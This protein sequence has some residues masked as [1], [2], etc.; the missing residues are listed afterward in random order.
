MPGIGFLESLQGHDGQKISSRARANRL[1]RASAVCGGYA[2]GLP[3]ERLSQLL[4]HDKWL[5]C[6]A[7]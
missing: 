6:E 5:G 2:V 4:W 1:G 7:W 3:F